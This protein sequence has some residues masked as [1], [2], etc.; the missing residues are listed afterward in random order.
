MKGLLVNIYQSGG[1][2]G[3]GDN[4]Y[5]RGKNLAILVG[6]TIPEIFEAG[7]DKPIYQLKFSR[8]FGEDYMYVEPLDPVPSGFVGYMASGK[9]VYS[10]DSRFPNNYP[11]AIHDRIEMS[12][13]KREEL[14]GGE[15]A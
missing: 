11:I 5:G 14:R 3:R 9:F 7:D 4:Q 15:G 10:S 1:Y 6:N 2:D 12:E 8:V 13:E